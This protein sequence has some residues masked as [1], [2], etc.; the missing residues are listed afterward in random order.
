MAKPST[1]RQTTCVEFPASLLQ[2]PANQAARAKERRRES[3]S[4]ISSASELGDRI[5]LDQQ[6]RG[7]PG[8][9]AREHL[10]LRFPALN[11]VR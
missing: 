7:R 3:R 5:D 1:A 11:S 8:I 4:F 9:P 6:R 10:D 2:A